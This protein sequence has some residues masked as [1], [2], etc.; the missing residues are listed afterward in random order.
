M[1]YC[2][3]KKLKYLH[4]L[5]YDIV[6]EYALGL[7]FMIVILNIKIPVVIVKYLLDLL[8]DN[9]SDGPKVL[10]TTLIMKYDVPVMYCG[11]ISSL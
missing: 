2:T 4:N 9:L 8:E 1:S 10:L 6:C 3:F 5:L 7:A 11:R